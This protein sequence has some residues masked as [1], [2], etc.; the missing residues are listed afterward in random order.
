M[1]VLVDAINAQ[2]LTKW[3][4]RLNERHATAFL[5]VG[6]GHDDKQWQITICVPEEISNSMIVAVLLKAVQELGG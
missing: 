5:L 1:T 6:V 2:R 3:A 4:T